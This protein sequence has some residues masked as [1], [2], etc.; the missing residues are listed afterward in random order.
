V[1]KVILYHEDYFMSAMD[2][3]YEHIDELIDD[4]K[5]VIIIDELKT[6][7]FNEK[8]YDANSFVYICDHFKDNVESIIQC[9]TETNDIHLILIGSNDSLDNSIPYAQYHSWYSQILD[10]ADMSF[11]LSTGINEIA[12]IE[13]PTPKHL[14]RTGEFKTIRYTDQ[15]GN[16]Y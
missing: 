8:T 11:V 16:L 13:Y 14:L 2:S 3:V 10:K 5:S 12:T 9:I 7:A 1:K 4:G 6:R 15:V